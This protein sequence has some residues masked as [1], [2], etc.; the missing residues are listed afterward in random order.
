MPRVK[1]LAVVLVDVLVVLVAKSVQAGV[2][3]SS[4]AEDEHFLDPG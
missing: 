4:V 1:G 3:G 2:V